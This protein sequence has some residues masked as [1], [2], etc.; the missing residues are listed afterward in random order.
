M[1]KIL[2]RLPIVKKLLNWVELQFNRL[3][4]ANSEYHKQ[5]IKLFTELDV[6]LSYKFEKHGETLRD[7]TDVTIKVVDKGIQDLIHS[8]KLECS[9][10]ISE[11]QNQVALIR[12]DIEPE[13]KEVTVV[14]DV[15]HQIPVTSSES[16][17]TEQLV[18]MELFNLV[19]QYKDA[20]NDYNRN[21]VAE[22]LALFSNRLAEASQVAIMYINQ[23]DDTRLKALANWAK[24]DLTNL[25]Y[26]NKYR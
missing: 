17:S 7:T 25:E 15:Y 16:Y 3:A 13:I 9:N 10:I 1:I 26:K 23:G 22:R 11:T 12:K 5:T 20:T 19:Q 2:K 18:S 14:N 24:G 6:T 21:K 8:L 4:I